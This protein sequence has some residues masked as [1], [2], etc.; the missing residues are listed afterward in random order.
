MLVVI[1]IGIIAV[2]ALPRL[3][4][5][6]STA[7]DASC[8]SNLQALMTANEQYKWDVGTYAPSAGNSVTELIDVLS[9]VDAGTGVRYLPANST[10][11]GECPGAGSDKGTYA[12]DADSGTISCSLHLPL[13]SP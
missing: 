4:V 11:S 10:V 7:A 12:Y 5:T 3:L 13:A 8:K 9:E 2:I 6:R 1:I